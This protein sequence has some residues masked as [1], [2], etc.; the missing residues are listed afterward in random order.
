METLAIAKGSNDWTPKRL[1]FQNIINSDEVISTMLEVIAIIVFAVI[2]AFIGL[3]Y[4]AVSRAKR[5][6]GQTVEPA[7]FKKL[8]LKK[9]SPALLYFTSPTCSMC[10]IQEQEIQGWKPRNVQ[11]VVVNV[12]QH[13]D[14]ARYFKIMGTPS[15]I[16]IDEQARVQEVLVG[17]Q[18]LSRLKHLAP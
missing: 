12:A 5:L 8:R 11:W 17:K 14:V 18:P 6:R 10:R 1:K 9:Q 4:F 7:I 16:L 15:F 2:F 3:Q 13:L